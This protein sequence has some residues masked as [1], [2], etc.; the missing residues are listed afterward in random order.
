MKDEYNSETPKELIKVRINSRLLKKENGLN[1]DH[2]AALESAL[3]EQLR[4]EKCNR[5][6]RENG[7]AIEEYNQFVDAYGTFSDSVRNF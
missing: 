4:T 6:M 2:S 7:A 1:I 3:E 5:W